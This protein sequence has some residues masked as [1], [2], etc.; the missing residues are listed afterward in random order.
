MSLINLG[1]IIFQFCVFF[2]Y[3]FSFNMLLLYAL[4]DLLVSSSLCLALFGQE[5]SWNMSF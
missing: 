2:V 1:Q 4:S 5:T 3:T